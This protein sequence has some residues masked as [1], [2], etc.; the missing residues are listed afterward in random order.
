VTTVDHHFAQDGSGSSSGRQPTSHERRSGR[1]WDASYHDGPAPWDVGHPQP[2]L[3]RVI[4]SAGLVA[5]VLDAGCGTGEHA[6]LT[7]SLGLAVVGVDVAPTAIEMAHAKAATRGLTVEFAVADALHLDRLGR[8]FRSVVDSGLFHTFDAEERSRYAASL[9]SVTASGGRVHVLC[10][11]DEGPER[12]GPHPIRQADLH[13]AFS[14]ATGW[15][16][17]SIAPDRIVTRFHADGSPAWLAAV[18]RV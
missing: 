11:S 12:T 4:R 10:F 16:I 8:S 1:P 7:A 9:A 3:E 2:A 18:T 13:A 5:P 15:R 6:L 17:E 14:P